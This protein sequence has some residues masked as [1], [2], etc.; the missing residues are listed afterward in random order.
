[1]AYKPLSQS[2]KNRIN[3]VLDARRA[4]I[5]IES[6]LM[7]SCE[8]Q[9]KKEDR[10]AF[11]VFLE[12]EIEHQQSIAAASTQKS[13]DEMTPQEAAQ[14]LNNALN[15]G[16]NVWT[17]LYEGFYGDA[18]SLSPIAKKQRVRFFNSRVFRLELLRH[19]VDSG[20]IAGV[21]DPQEIKVFFEG[22]ALE[23]G[24]IGESKASEIRALPTPAFH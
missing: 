23:C 11:E 10:P 3:Q 19:H 16:E 24:L 5:G 9:A 4:C 14:S 17:S 15:A 22:K 8:W 2:E 13:F 7:E 21:D 1:M 18:T 20:S 12:S 6:I